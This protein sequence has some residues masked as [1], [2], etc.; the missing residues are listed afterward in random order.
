MTQ[1]KTKYIAPNAQIAH[2]AQHDE[3]DQNTQSQIER[4]SPQARNSEDPHKAKSGCVENPQLEL[5]FDGG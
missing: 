1:K 2:L 5:E 3:D 4:R